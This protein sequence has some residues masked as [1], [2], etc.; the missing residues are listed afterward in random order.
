[1]QNKS[2][3]AIKGKVFLEFE[4]SYN[5]IKA[6]LKTIFTP[7]ENKVLEDEK[8]RFN[9]THF[10]RNALRLK[11]LV[12]EV[13]ESTNFVKSCLE[14]DCPFRTLTCLLFI[15]IFV[16][17]IEWYMLPLTLL[18][19]MLR[20]FIMMNLNQNYFEQVE[21][22]NL[23]DEAKL[24]TEKFYEKIDQTVNFFINTIL[25]NSSFIDRIEK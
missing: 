12:L 1:M 18:L 4:I 13:I 11:H 23:K 10:L 6:A 24:K 9:K 8:I 19:I 17:Y 16:Y 14:W 5:P 2:Q 7:K 20:N 3:N 21:K 15:L 22:D 25:E